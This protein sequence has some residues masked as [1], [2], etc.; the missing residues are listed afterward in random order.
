MYNVLNLEAR[1]N[2][3]QVS[4]D[5]LLTYHEKGRDVELAFEWNQIK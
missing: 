5:V 1:K 3:E 2:N 4:Q